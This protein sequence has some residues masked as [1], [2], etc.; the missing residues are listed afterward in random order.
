MPTSYGDF[1][2]GVDDL[3][4]DDFVGSKGPSFDMKVKHKTNVD[5]LSVDSALTFNNLFSET[6]G[7]WSKVTGKTTGK[8]KHPCGF[9]LKKLEHS[10]EATKLEAE[11]D[12]NDLLAGLT[13]G[14]KN[15]FSHKA[16]HATKKASVSATLEQDFANVDATFDLKTNALSVE[17][18]APVPAVAG[19]AVGFG[20]N[21]AA[22]GLDVD[23]GALF[24]FGDGE[25]AL[26]L[27]NLKDTSNLGINANIGYTCTS[28]FK[29]GVQTSHGLIGDDDK[30]EA[31]KIGAVAQYAVMDGLAAKA[32]VNHSLALGAQEAGTSVGLAFDY[33]PVKGIQLKP[34]FEFAGGSKSMSLNVTLG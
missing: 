3:I 20:A 22:S 34:A 15:E 31:T 16:A 21:Y 30:A 19:L 24:N 18:G 10:G 4:G 5:G 8:F 1:L 33:K 27:S 23:V 32:R 11:Y 29:F 7:N 6:S 12:A 2:S 17:V 25:F 26:K 14:S 28:D 13:L 9:N